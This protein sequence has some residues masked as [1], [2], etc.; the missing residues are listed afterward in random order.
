ME[1]LAAV[2]FDSNARRPV[3]WQTQQRVDFVVNR[4]MQTHRGQSEDQ[5]AQAIKESLRTLGVVP[6][7]RE[8]QQYAAAIAQLPLLPPKKA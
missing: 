7:G 2:S 5:V 4:I 6:N 3:G 1:P 8:V